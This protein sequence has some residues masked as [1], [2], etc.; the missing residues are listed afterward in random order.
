MKIICLTQRPI[1][2][3][4]L[5]YLLGSKDIFFDHIF[6]SPL[7]KKNSLGFKDEGTHSW[8]ALK[9][10]CKLL[11]IP[12]DNIL[13]INS[14]KFLRILKKIN[15]DCM[16]SLVVDTIYSKKIISVFKK[17]IYSSHGGIMP[18]YRGNDC[19]KWAILNNEKYVGISLQKIN[20]GID[21]GRIVKVSKFATKNFKSIKDIDKKL[22]YQFKLNDFVDI[23]Q[24]LKKNKKI[25]FL[26]KK[27]IG[28]QYFEMHRDLEKIVSLKL[29]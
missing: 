5:I 4:I 3:L 12:F 20:K 6:Y 19:S 11:D 26:K 29:K 14:K 24:K 13:N 2:A 8:K 1:Q 15:P 9:Y 27:K 18:K 17:G 7:K 28:K 23:A 25:K 16:I 22:Y 10:Q 21:A